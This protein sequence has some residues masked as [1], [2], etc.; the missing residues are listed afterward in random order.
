MDQIIAT[1]SSRILSEQGHRA[2]LLQ[3]LAVFTLLYIKIYIK[4]YYSLS[5]LNFE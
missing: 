3:M 4:Y 5:I 2:F 1:L